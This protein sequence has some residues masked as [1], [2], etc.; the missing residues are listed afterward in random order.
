MVCLLSHLNFCDFLKPFLDILT[1]VINLIYIDPPKQDAVSIDISKEGPLTDNEDTVTL[2]CE[3]EANP[4]PEITWLRSSGNVSLRNI[5]AGK[6][7]FQ[8]FFSNISGH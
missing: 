2:S 7:N 8:I 6:N 4:E 1:Y 5:F 3:A